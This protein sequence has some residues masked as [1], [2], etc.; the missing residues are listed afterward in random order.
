LSSAEIK[1]PGLVPGKRYRMVIETA[2]SAG[3]ITVGTTSVPSI[4][5]VV[6]SANQLLS[7]YVPN[8][9]TSVVDYPGT[10]ANSVEVSREKQWTTNDPEGYWSEYTNTAKSK[11][12]NNTP[13][14]RASNLTWANWYVFRF[15][16]LSG[17]P[18]VGQTF[19]VSGMGKT[20]TSWYYD[21]LQYKCEAHTSNNN[22][23]ATA[24]IVNEN[25]WRKPPNG[26]SSTEQSKTT[27]DRWRN[28][29][30][31]PFVGIETDQA[32]PT[33]S[34]TESTR[35]W[36]DPD[37]ETVAL[38]DKVKYADYVA[39]WSIISVTTSLPASINLENNISRDGKRVVELPVF[40]YIENGIFKDM[41]NNVMSG[42]PPAITTVP[43]AIPRS[44]TNVNPKEVSSS[45]I[46]LRSYRFTTAK[47]TLDNG[48]WSAQW[49]QF[50]DRYVSEPLMRNVIYSGQAI[51]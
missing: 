46:S 26:T 3:N 20:S 23:V 12:C 31:K 41:D 10:P 50:D 19:Y 17:V 13:T 4:E 18:P 39:P 5:F 8:Y 16:S 27:R 28:Q 37:P 45:Q 40:F 2:N 47:Y 35:S 15:D 44:A 1:I 29:G 49:S 51:L 43:S 33:L 9:R 36:I 42:L 32:T 25:S 30:G 14:I 34:W 21:F 48:L 38:P 22:I 6:P 7:T 24:I 11:K